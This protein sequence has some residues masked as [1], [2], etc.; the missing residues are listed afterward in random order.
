MSAPELRHLS[1]SSISSYLLCP[2][3]W[4][5]HYID[6]VKTP[7]AAALTFGSTFHNVIESAIRDRQNG[8]RYDLAAMWLQ[9]WAQH[10]EATAEQ[11]EWGE[12]SW[13][14]LHDEGLRMLTLPQTE[15]LVRGLVPLVDDVGPWVERKVELHVPG[16]PFPVIGYI[17]LITS[18]GIVT[19]FKTAGRAWSDDQAQKESQPSYYLAALNQ[20]GF[21]FNPGRRFRHIIWT[22]GKNPKV[23]TFET[24]RGWADLLR[25]FTQITEVWRGIEAGVFPYNTGSWKCPKYCDYAR[26]CQGVG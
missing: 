13:Q 6:Q 10:Q 5:Y 24:Q 17:D 7:T 18:D 3:A 9:D 22:K 16:V 14:Q 12:T 20:M 25:L 19:D 1:Y 8:G 26:Q 23:Q 4:K 15:Q 11:I 2:R 21:M